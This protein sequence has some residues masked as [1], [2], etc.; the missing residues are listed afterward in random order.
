MRK[1]SLDLLNALR[2]AERDLATGSRG[3]VTRVLQNFEPTTKDTGDITALV[4]TLNKRLS[5]ADQ[6][7][8][9]QISVNERFT[10][11]AGSTNAQ[12]TRF[13]PVGASYEDLVRN[14]RVEVRSVGEQFRDVTW[15][16][17]GYNNLLFISILLTDYL[18]RRRDPKLA[19][20]IMAIEEPEAHLHPQLQKLLNRNFEQVARS[21]GAQV[22]ATTH[23]THITSSVS[24]DSLVVY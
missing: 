6:I 13:S 4:T 20:P 3:N 14:L 2:D 17:L 21:R 11:V 16:G 8:D 23:S 5:K 19:L 22:I 15:N 12:P 24:L 1:I 9:A 10:E 18:E 7:K